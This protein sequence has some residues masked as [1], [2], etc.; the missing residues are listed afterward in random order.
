MGIESE[1][2][3]MAERIKCPECNS[4]QIELLWSEHSGY[5]NEPV[6]EYYCHD[7]KCNFEI[8]FAPK[9]IKILKNY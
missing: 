5:I 9:T 6:K 1:R 2:M 3:T 4:N 7:C 8:I